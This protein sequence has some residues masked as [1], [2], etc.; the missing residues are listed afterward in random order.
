MAEKKVL[1]NP[2][3]LRIIL[4]YAGVTIKKKCN[5]CGKY[6]K[7]QIFNQQIEY[8]HES[9]INWEICKKIN[10]CSDECLYIYKQ[11][12]NN[13]R[14]C[15]FCFLICIISGLIICLIVVLIDIRVL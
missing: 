5:I 11:S 12:F 6:L 1:T 2:N 9:Y 10:F 3:L 15:F 14:I 7:Y 4:S 13:E 8:E